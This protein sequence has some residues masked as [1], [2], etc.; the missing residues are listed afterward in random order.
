MRHSPGL[1]MEGPLS[2]PRVAEAGRVLYAQVFGRRDGVSQRG[3]AGGDLTGFYPNPTLT[4]T[5]VS[6]ATYGSATQVAQ[7]TLDAKGRATSAS[8]VAIAGLSGQTEG[9]VF[10]PPFVLQ[11]T[12]VTAGNYGNNQTLAY[13]AVDAYGRITSAGQNGL[14]DAMESLFLGG[15]ATEFVTDGATVMWVNVIVDDAELQTAGRVFRGPTVLV[16]AD[17]LHSLPPSGV[18]AGVY[19]SATQVAQVTLDAKGRVTAAAGV[20][21]SGVGGVAP[22][23][24]ISMYGGS[25]V[26]TGW[27][28][29]DGSAVSRAT[30]ADL[31]TAIST[32]WGA[33]DGSTTFNLPDL[34]GRAPI[35]VGTGSGL[36]ARTLAGTGGAETHALSEAELATHDHAVT[37]PGHTHAPATGDR[38]YTRD[39]GSG[40]GQIGAGSNIRIET[41]TGSATT[42]LT[43][44]NAGSGDAHN[45]M[46]PWAAVRF[47]IKI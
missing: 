18:T 3:V 34:R 40:T 9:R 38:F 17:L 25:S 44:D 1:G 12:G 33:G 45:N 8:N 15:L 30:Y 26:P 11:R 22:A 13:F 14:A 41:A 24:T 4:T 46:Q 16:P 42:G 21:I 43:V 47:I 10:N 29:C 6:A 39:V 20:T 37:D 23:G 35:G 5:G 2:A 7:V 19:G 28:E 32:T 27:L 36:T 31:F